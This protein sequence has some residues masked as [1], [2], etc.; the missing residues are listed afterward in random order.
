MGE[1]KEAYNKIIAPA[2]QQALLTVGAAEAQE[3]KI[4]AESFGQD[5]D[6]YNFWRTLN[7]Y[8]RS[9]PKGSRGAIFSTD[10][11]FLKLLS[12]MESKG[13]DKDQGKPKRK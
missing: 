10:S 11:S 6:F 4:K 1:T 9:L 13:Q 5:I 7:A 8:K 12:N 2:I 3:A